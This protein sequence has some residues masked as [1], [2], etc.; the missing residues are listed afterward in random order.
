MR[1]I[2]ALSLPREKL[3]E[4]QADAFKKLMIGALTTAKLDTMASAQRALNAYMVLEQGILPKDE[5]V[6]AWLQENEGDVIGL[7]IFQVAPGNWKFVL[8]AGT[9]AE[10]R[11]IGESYNG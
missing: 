4:F 5:S 10:L 2:G 3:L 9:Q 7:M 8:A 6:L 1:L 11:Q